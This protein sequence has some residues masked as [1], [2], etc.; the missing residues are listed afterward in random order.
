[1]SYK[2]YLQTNHWKRLRR[3]KLEQAGYKCEQCESTFWLAVHHVSYRK[4]WFDSQPEDLKVLCNYC[5]KKAHGILKP[6]DRPIYTVAQRDSIVKNLCG[7]H[8]RTYFAKKF[9]PPTP[10][11]QQPKQKK[12]KKKHHRQHR[13][14]PGPQYEPKIL[15]WHAEEEDQSKYVPGPF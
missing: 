11:K 12:K 1:M 8:V 3:V 15:S 10:P 7:I 9:T 5:H 13:K 2:E 4:S 14:D 6:N